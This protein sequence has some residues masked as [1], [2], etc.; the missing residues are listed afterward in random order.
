MISL[1][2]RISFKRHNSL[3]HLKS[4]CQKIDFR[5]IFIILFYLWSDLINNIAEKYDLE[6]TQIAVSSVEDD[7]LTSFQVMPFF[8]ES[9]DDFQKKMDQID[10]DVKLLI[11]FVVVFLL[12]NFIF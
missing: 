4:K 3:K 2:N 1:L 5:E 9:V 12:F 8:I 7:G 11:S 10:I 6:R